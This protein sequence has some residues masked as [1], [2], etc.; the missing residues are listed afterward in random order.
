MTLVEKLFV[1]CLCD[2]NIRISCDIRNLTA[3]DIWHQNIR[4]R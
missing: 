2:Y 3:P 1:V 4:I